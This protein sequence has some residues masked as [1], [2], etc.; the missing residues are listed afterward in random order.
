MHLGVGARVDR[1]ELNQIKHL[2]WI[3]CP[4]TADNEQTSCHDVLH[5][6]LERIYTYIDTCIVHAG[7]FA[8]GGGACLRSAPPSRCSAT[9]CQNEGWRDR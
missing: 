8:T 4:G 9:V 7:G 5:P 2:A 3:R 6:D 1:F